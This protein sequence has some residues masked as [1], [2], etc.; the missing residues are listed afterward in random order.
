MT[1][2]TKFLTI[3][4]AAELLNVS[5]ASLRRWTNSGRLHCYR[6]GDRNERRFNMDDLLNL[7]GGAPTKKEDQRPEAASAPIKT[8]KHRHVCFFYKSPKEQWQLFR[9]YFLT[10]T[11]A[12]SKIIYLYHGDR[13]RIINWLKNESIDAEA[14]IAE[15]SL[16]MLSTAEAYHPNGY[17]NT[18]DMLAF[19]KEIIHNAEQKGVSKLLLTGEMGWA[20][21]NLPGHE[22]LLPYESALDCMLESY[23]WV[24]V[25]CQYPVYQISGSTV[26]D[27]LCVHTHV[28]L[29][30]RLASGFGAI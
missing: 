10:H 22:Q 13:D 3:A 4:E 18:D 14:M 15:G 8:D 29:A 30:D 17:F 19:W 21:S 11:D 2:S 5:K 12:Y 28:Q 9:E 1:E 25:V 20:N 24:T 7:I 23:P 26:F 27:N 6:V 16:L